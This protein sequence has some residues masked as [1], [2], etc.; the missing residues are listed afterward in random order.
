MFTRCYVNC[1]KEC[2]GKRRA[3]TVVVEE[4][5][6]KEITVYVDKDNTQERMEEALNTVKDMIDS[7]ELTVNNDSGFFQRDY[8]ILDED[9]GVQIEF[10]LDEDIKKGLARYRRLFKSND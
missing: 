1:R 2:N 9:S 5:H 4:T 8:E 3:V 10:I 7:N 6:L